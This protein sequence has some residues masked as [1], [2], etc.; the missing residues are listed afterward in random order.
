MHRIPYNQDKRIL[1][2]LPGG[3][4]ADITVHILNV[5]I[6]WFVENNYHISKFTTDDQVMALAFIE[7]TEPLLAV[8]SYYK[9]QKEDY[10]PTTSEKE[11]NNGIYEIRE[12]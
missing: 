10:R 8:E 9:I 2:D 3:K 11:K 1:V 7:D 12:E 5:A 6:R 4:T